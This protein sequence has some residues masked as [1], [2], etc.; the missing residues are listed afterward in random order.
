MS[1]PRRWTPLDPEL[2][3]DCAVFTV[4]RA[5]ARSPAGDAHDFYRID[6][7]DWVNVV[8]LTA[9]GEVVMIRQYRHGLRDLTLE[10]PGGLIDPGEAPIEAAGRELF[11]ETGYR[12]GQLVPIGAT[13]PNPALFGN[14]VHTFLATALERHGEPTNPGNEET[15]VELVP[16]VDL[17]GIVRRGGVDHALVI[18]ALHFLD[19]HREAAEPGSPTDRPR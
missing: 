7:S 19:L 10:I 5:P 8:P 13:S 9:G 2:L 6:S 1:G 11:E 12:A 3:Q 14:R 15:V 18:A 4:S 17:R 16:E